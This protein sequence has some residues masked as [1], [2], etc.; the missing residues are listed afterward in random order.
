MAQSQPQTQP[1]PQPQPSMFGSF[2]TPTASNPNSEV[3]TLIL[4][5]LFNTDFFKQMMNGSASTPY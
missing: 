1:Q 5:G 3:A 4:N 2:A